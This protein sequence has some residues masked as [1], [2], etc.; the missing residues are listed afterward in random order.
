MKKIF[1][2]FVAVTALL[3][4]CHDNN[5]SSDSD[6]TVP[7][8]P[9]PAAI[10]YSLVKVYPH[11]TS[12]YT[13][14]LIWQNNKLYEG[15]GMRGVSKLRQVDIN[16]GKPIREITLPAT[17]FGEGIT[18]LNNKIYQL[19]WEEHKVYVYDASTFK[20]LQ[21]LPWTYEGWGL[22]NNGKQLIVTTSDSNL[23]FVNPET[24]RI[25]KTVGVSDNNGYVASINEL[26]YVN[27]S[28][29]ANVYGADYIIKINPESGKVEGRV[30]LSDILQKAGAAYDPRQVD[31]GYVLNGIAYDAAKNSFYITG[32]RWP[33]LCEVKFN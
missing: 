9:P 33:I 30:D 8:I 15:T 14:G 24:F 1:P 23:Y 7:A 29:Y 18:L 11:D 22:T 5:K 26:E 21:E 25:E 12:S 20:K 6:V 4:A 2:V 28:I 19:T 31:S 27:G 13:Q 16:T 10:S 17:D 3:T 32:K